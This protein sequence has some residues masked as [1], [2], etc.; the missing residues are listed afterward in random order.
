[1]RISTLFAVFCSLFLASC[2]Y[3]NEEEL[4]PAVVLPDQ[5]TYSVH[6]EPIMRKS[7]A[8]SGCHVPG[9]TGLGLLTNYNEV[10]AIADNGKLADRVLVKED[11]PS[12]QPLP[13]N[14]QALIQ[15]WIDQ[16]TPN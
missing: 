4:Y 13:A 2:Y 3:D 15:A 9:G 11:M 1:M 5:V 8:V 6:I 14:E 7:C 12:S 16:G 10:K